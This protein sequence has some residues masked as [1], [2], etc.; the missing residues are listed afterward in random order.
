MPL[1]NVLSVCNWIDV[2][3]TTLRFFSFTSKPA[4]N[5]RGEPTPIGCYNAIVDQEVVD[6]IVTETNR[7]SEQKLERHKSKAIT[8][9]KLMKFVGMVC[10]VGLVTY[11]KTSNYLSKK[12]FTKKLTYLTRCH[13]TFLL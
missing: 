5:F 7:F 4:I 3:E 8:G 1:T 13:A 2:S 6:L 9:D 10:Y 11:T 12:R